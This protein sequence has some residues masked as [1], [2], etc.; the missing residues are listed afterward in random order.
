MKRV[1]IPVVNGHLSEYFG[2]CNHYEIFS[3]DD[4]TIKSEAVEI[5]P[6]SDILKLP[7]WA[8]GEG[9]TDIITYKIDKQIMGLFSPYRIN[10]FV[11]IPIESPR[12]LIDDYLNGRLKSDEA[13]IA[14]IMK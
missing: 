10:L 11:G 3:I 7:E 14:E 9:I 1:A 12:N 4:N 8:A 5:P 2:Q 6:K 13:I